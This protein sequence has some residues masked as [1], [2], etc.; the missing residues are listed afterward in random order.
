MW[1]IL[2]QYHHHCRSSA[3]LCPK[4]FLLNWDLGSF[5]MCV[6]LPSGDCALW[7]AKDTF[8]HTIKS[9]DEAMLSCPKFWA[10]HQNVAAEIEVLSSEMVVK[11]PVDVEKY[12]VHLTPRHIIK[13][14]KSFSVCMSKYQWVVC[15]L[16]VLLMALALRR[17]RTSVTDNVAVK[18]EGAC[19][20]VKPNLW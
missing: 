3:P 12:S 4:A 13:S 16:C 1:S 20:G 7:A 18:V 5:V 8:S 19:C 17:I 10:Y 15:V 11:V 2:T 14:L 9:M 6:L